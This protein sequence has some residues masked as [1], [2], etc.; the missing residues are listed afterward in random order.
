M[1]LPPDCAV[2]GAVQ[3]TVSALSEVAATVGRG[4]ANGAVLPGVA[5]AVA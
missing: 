3:V 1:A 2:V 5:V 4:I